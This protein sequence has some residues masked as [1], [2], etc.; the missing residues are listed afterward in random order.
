MKTKCAGVVLLSVFLAACGTRSSSSVAPVT[1]ASPATQPATVL[2]KKTPENIIITENDITDRRYRAL[3]DIKVNVAKWTLFD[4][5]PTREKVNEAL[6]EKAASMG[7]DA[8]VL[9]RYGTLGMSL[10]SYGELDGNGR[11]VVFEK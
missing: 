8:V 10:L 4:K 5:D 2:P 1:G 6:Q 7:A 3:G 9:V 11:A